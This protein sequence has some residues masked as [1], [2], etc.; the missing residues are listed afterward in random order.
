MSV[1]AIMI[2]FSLI[3]SIVLIACSGLPALLY[4]RRSG[5]GQI[6]STT[7]LA[8][9][10]AIGIGTL[11]AYGIYG[12]KAYIY[13][14]PW[15]TPLGRLPIKLDALAALFLVP[16][17]SISAL[18]SIYGLGYWPQR[19][20]PANGRRLGLFWGWMTA[21]MALVVLAGQMLVFLSGWE[22]MALS[23]YFLLTTEDSDPAARHA[24]WVYF[25]ATHIATLFLIAFFILLGMAHGSLNLWPVDMPGGQGNLPAALFILGLIGFGLKAGLVPLHIWLPGAHA[26]APSHVSALFSGVMLTM[27]IYGLVRIA[28]LFAQPPLWWGISFLL[29]GIVSAFLGI[30]WAAAQQDFKKMMAF[31]SIENMG[32]VT[33]GLGVA[34][35]GVSL[36]HPILV[37]LGLSGALL[38]MLNHSLFKPLLFMGAG[39]IIH[40]THHRT[41]DSLGGLAK[42]MPRTFALMLLGVMAITGLPPLNG[43][44][45]E[46]IIYMGLLGTAME[47]STLAL[48]AIIAVLL[49][50]TGALALAAFTTWLST[51]FSGRPRSAATAKAHDP[52]RFMLVPMGILAGL[53]L[54][55]GIMPVLIA[56]ALG[57]ALAA[58]RPDIHLPAIATLVPLRYFTLPA[59]LL[60]VVGLMVWVA[61]GPLRRLTD[62]RTTVSGTGTWDCGYAF[63]TGRM[64]YSGASLLQISTHFFR[65]IIWPQRQTPDI[66][67]L[68][69]AAERFER[70]TPDPLLDRIIEPA[71]DRA[72]R[73]AVAVR[74]VQSGNVQIY[75]LYIFVILLTLLACIVFVR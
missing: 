67:G 9:G 56:P 69:P 62:K 31:S 15:S 26:N 75:I 48:I 1:P 35:L 37:T 52:S 63:P 34:A 12:A 8:T 55:I 60:A 18:G 7:L 65:G 30:V 61:C 68:F 51:C 2:I 27:G 13:I 54:L 5:H 22:L 42:P 39:G 38:H 40:A 66:R 72:Q 71:A 4:R 50:M 3:F 57:S 20:N 49:A 29:V 47:K 28:G 14:P 73:L 41:M 25:I 24:G 36:H 10:C 23:G 64:A 59:L 70:T 46:W 16:I 19:H 17:F 21:G 45:S 32:I 58:W 6:L 43:F 53:C 11:A 74:V 33:V 44:V